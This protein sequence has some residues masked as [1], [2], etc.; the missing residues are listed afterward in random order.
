[1]T[2]RTCSMP[3][4][5]AWSGLGYQVVTACN[6]VDAAR[7]LEEELP[8]A[9]VLDVVMPVQDG[10]ETLMEIRRRNLDLKVI[11]V[12]G[13]GRIT[14]DGLSGGRRVRWGRTGFWRSRSPWRNSTRR[15]G[16][17]W[18]EPG[19]GAASLEARQRDGAGGNSLLGPLDLGGEVCR[20]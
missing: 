13:G 7:R 2:I 20:G 12:S 14:F 19:G 4:V 3:F 5:V 11:V 15:S 1:M 10:I 8:E 18:R 9:M 17:C 16:G 6:G